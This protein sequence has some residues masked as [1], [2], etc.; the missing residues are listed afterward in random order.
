ME[1]ER[2]A[3]LDDLGSHLE[4]HFSVFCGHHNLVVR[5]KTFLQ[6]RTS[7]LEHFRLDRPMFISFNNQT[8]SI[9]TRSYLHQP[10]PADSFM[11][12]VSIADPDYVDKV[13]KILKDEI[14]IA[15][16]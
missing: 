14:K 15:K 12:E 1:N 16:R 7:L 9:N 8:L 5:D 6:S 4:P 3:I 10:R 13:I 11:T 2:L